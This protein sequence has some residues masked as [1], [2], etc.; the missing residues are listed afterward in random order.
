MTAAAANTAKNVLTSGLF[1]GAVAAG[2]I[3]LLGR[4]AGKK[5]GRSEGTVRVPVNQE[6]LRLGF[7][8]A[9]M[10][11]KVAGALQG[12]DFWSAPKAEVLT[13]LYYLNDAELTAVYNEYNE[14][15]LDAPETLASLIRGEWIWG[16]GKQRLLAR[17]DQIGLV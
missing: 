11:Q 8:A 9:Q 6:E 15:Y 5:K 17:M 13:E 12:W 3:Y 4:S 2:G 1:L 16:S 14:R 10:A 7:D